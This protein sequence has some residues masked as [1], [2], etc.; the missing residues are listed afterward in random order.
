M[1]T[2]SCLKI[3]TAKWVQRKHKIA[4]TILLS[5]F[6]IAHLYKNAQNLA[7]NLRATPE[8]KFTLNPSTSCM[9]RTKI[10]SQLYFEFQ[11]SSSCIYN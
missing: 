11:R 9:P 8:T 5:P 2:M 1:S 4:Q 6:M 3:H 10:K 7:F